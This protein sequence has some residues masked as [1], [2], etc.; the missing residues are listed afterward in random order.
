MNEGVV[1]NII[2]YESVIE[3]SRN[4]ED[5]QANQNANVRNVTVGHMGISWGHLP[6]S[7]RPPPECGYPS[8]P[9]VDWG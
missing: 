8:L 6:P 2:T 4:F 3:L 7:L 9:F 1:M 5:L